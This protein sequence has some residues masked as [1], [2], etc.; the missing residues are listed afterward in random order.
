M[1]NKLT[2][3]TLSSDSPELDPALKLYVDT[4]QTESM[5][6]YNFNFDHPKTADQYYKAVQLMAK[7]LIVQGDDIFIANFEN[8]V[9]GIAVV[10]KETKGSFSEMLNV[11]FPEVFKLLPLLTK[12]NYRNLLTSSQAAKLS[13]PLK[14]NYVTLQIVA[15]SSVYQGQGIGKRF[16][17]EIHDRYSKDYDGIYLYTADYKNKEIYTYFGYELIEKTSSGNL[18]VYHMV[19]NY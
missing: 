16:F 14:G 12:I 7:V 11:L 15:V 10:N 17:Q 2:F 13:N 19:Y 18:D 5:T 6:S 1:K 9:V 4:F 3:Y 8:D